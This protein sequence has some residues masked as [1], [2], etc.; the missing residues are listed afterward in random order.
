MSDDPVA[1]LITQLE[2]H[3][4]H[5]AEEHE[6]VL[7]S[8]GDCAWCGEGIVHYLHTDRTIHAALEQPV[9][10]IIRDT[11]YGLYVCK[12]CSG[13][14]KSLY[15]AKTHAETCQYRCGICNEKV[16]YTYPEAHTHYSRCA[17]S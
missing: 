5:A 16:G 11:K 17:M 10:D 12:K 7:A 15:V 4:R 3:A 9:T 6:F 1:D 13:T 14:F 8:D 2:A